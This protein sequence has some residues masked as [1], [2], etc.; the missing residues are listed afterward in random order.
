[1][2]QLAIAVQCNS[3]LQGLHRV[4]KPAYK[5]IDG[6][7]NKLQ[8]LLLLI[9][10]KKGRLELIVLAGANGHHNCFV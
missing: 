10:L 5:F 4:A 6:L 8:V 7:L 3:L 9:L 1:M 2:R